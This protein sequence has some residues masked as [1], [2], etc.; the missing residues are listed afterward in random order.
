MSPG[1]ADPQ[2]SV[3]RSNRLLGLRE[4]NQALA[5][6]K[7]KLEFALSR[8]NDQDTQRTGVEEIREFLQNLYPDWFPVVIGCIAEA[9]GNLKPAGRCE[10][11]KL[12]GLL[13]ELHGDAV[14]PLLPRILQVVVMRLQD[15]DLHLREACAET[16]FRLARALVVDVEC[17][18]A[19]A[20]LLKPLF[21]ALGE[22]SKWVQIGA[23]ACIC[24]VIQGSPSEVI[25]ENLGRLCSRL[26]QHLS[27]P[28]AMARPQLLSACI[29]AMQAVEGSDFDE[30]LP[31]LMPC[32][33]TCLSA[34]TDWQTR[35]QAIE[36]LQAIGENPELGQSLELPPPS[37]ELPWPTPLQRRIAQMLEVLKTDKVRAVREAVKEVLLSWSIA[38]ATPV[39]FPTAIRSSSPA[40]GTMSEPMR[41]ASDRN[42]N[43]AQ[44]APVAHRSSSPSEMSRV[45]VEKSTHTP[46]GGRGRAR[47]LRAARD[48]E[49]E[50]S[51]AVLVPERTRTGVSP[52]PAQVPEVGDAA[53]AE[54]AART[55]AVKSALSGAV[56]KSTQRARPKRERQSIFN[57][58]S[59]PDF[60]KLA[61]SS[62]GGPGAAGES[63]DFGEED[64][65]TEPRAWDDE[66]P[67]TASRELSVQGPPQGADASSTLSDEEE[68][69][70]KPRPLGGR[71]Q[72]TRASLSSP[73]EVPP[74]GATSSRDVLGHRESETVKAEDV[75]ANG[76]PRDGSSWPDHVP[77]PPAVA[78]RDIGAL[79]GQSAHRAARRSPGPARSRGDRR[80]PA[81]PALVEPPDPPER[82]SS[83]TTLG[84]RQRP[85][86]PAS[87]ESQDALT[88]SED[89]LE[90]LTPAPTS[91][92]QP[93]ASPLDAARGV[94][95]SDP[96]GRGLGS[97]AERGAANLALDAG[98][99]QLETSGSIRLLLA[100]FEALNE[101]LQ[102]LEEEKQDMEERLTSR[103]RALEHS[104][105][106][107]REQLLVHGRELKEQE[108]RLQ[109]QEQ[110]LGVQDQLI[111]EQGQQLEQ[112]E[113]QL[114]EQSKELKEQALQL[115]QLEEQ[116]EEQ[117]AERDRQIAENRSRDEQL[118]SQKQLVAELL[119]AS[120]SQ[121]DRSIERSVRDEDPRS[122]APSPGLERFHF[123]S[124]REVIESA[125]SMGGSISDGALSGNV[126]D[127][128]L[129]AASGSFSVTPVA[130]A[131]SRRPTLDEG[132][133]GSSGDCPSATSLRDAGLLHMS[134]DGLGS[135]ASRGLV[136][137]T[138]LLW[139][140]VIEL[141]DAERFL[142][143]YKQVIAEPEET[144]LLRLMLYTGPIVERLDAES[145]SRLIRRLIHILSSPAKE[146]TT[147]SIEQIFSWL[148]QALD[149]GIHFTSSQVEDLSAA[150][151][152]VAAKHSAL[153]AADR[154][155]AARLLTRVTAL[156]RQ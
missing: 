16:V 15:A 117:L 5:E 26:V 49:A 86:P 17:S 92:S 51:V 148:R 139:E 83:E 124:K 71:G 90:L 1:G 115:Q 57:G 56:L 105:E 123:S 130:E 155:D 156:R 30:A 77:D 101:K 33:E 52:A 99:E 113:L 107:Q 76:Q 122:P 21:G 41:V 135:G 127:F 8:L 36:V 70:P 131:I 128:G 97:E 55:N 6:L 39:A 116:F 54:K 64:E 18:Q 108:S 67:E 73:P 100:Q 149:A 12:L 38:K 119:A 93:L 109:A 98:A 10:S 19:F 58:P 150:L 102:V 27:L 62:P 89:E 88:Y 31:A 25:G 45:E 37:S 79:S 34:P 104:I 47:S 48:R 142:E 59:N 154:A 81:P 32:L 94:A 46:T 14:L 61:A 126:G 29:Y 114:K 125:P 44:G 112:R 75:A 42:I 60:F 132:I 147:S 78:A 85:G 7:T 3:L 144:C 66:A 2:L 80:R 87:G 35:K 9:G 22:H 91:K 143:A 68:A 146:P 28:L 141:C 13:A 96:G 24:S 4:S 145:N 40:G 82:L 95:T 72:R 129:R 111:G 103:V 84:D 106:G 136:K 43:A 118:V 151:Q 74:G 69:M 153:P 53:A 11:V 140:K 152:K 120:A 133:A 23:A 63:I 121:S 134:L 138:G 50:D 65:Q 137:K 110:Q 20:T